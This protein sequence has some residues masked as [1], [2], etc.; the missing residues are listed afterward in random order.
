MSKLFYLGS[1]IGAY[2]AVFASSFVA[3]ALSA[4]HG[5]SLWEGPAANWILL[6]GVSTIYLWVIL[7]VLWWKAWKAIQP[8]GGRTSPG[9]AIGFLFI[10][11]VNIYWIFQAFWGYSKDFNSNIDEYGLDIPR[12]PEGL[13]LAFTLTLLAVPLLSWIR[14]LNVLLSL[15][16]VVFTILVVNKLVD[17]V[18]NIGRAPLPENRGLVF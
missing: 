11:A 12:L 4:M 9:Q 14:P 16:L 13:F 5:G 1:V 15:A 8:Y 17:A 6:A 3:G 10:P 18:N 2:A 7:L